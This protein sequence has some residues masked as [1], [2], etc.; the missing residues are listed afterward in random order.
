[1]M[2]QTIALED[3]TDPNINPEFKPFTPFFQSLA[4]GE[5]IKIAKKKLAWYKDCESFRKTLTFC[6]L[7]KWASRLKKD[8][9]LIISSPKLGKHPVT[10]L[11][12]GVTPEKGG[13]LVKVKAKMR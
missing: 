1:M 6:L 10:A 7:A 2:I 12:M 3:V 4:G 11:I 8:T 5:A 13:V 9:A